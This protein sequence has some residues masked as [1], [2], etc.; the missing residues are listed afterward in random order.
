MPSPYHAC[1]R[2][3]APNN[4]IDAILVLSLVTLTNKT[5]RDTHHV[6]GT[7][8]NDKTRRN[9][10][11]RTHRYTQHNRRKVD[12]SATRGYIEVYIH[13]HTH[14]RVTSSC[15]ISRWQA[16]EICGCGALV[17]TG[18]TREETNEEK[19]LHEAPNGMYHA[20]G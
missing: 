11:I 2:T 6:G 19:K 8:W 16:T 1:L 18:V 5:R 13:T 12:V 14:V 7:H 9:K 4:F 3:S 10:Y 15:Y 20:L 17:A